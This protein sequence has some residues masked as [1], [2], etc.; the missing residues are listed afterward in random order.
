[1]RASRLLSIVL[2]LQNRGRLTGSELAAELEVSVRTIYRDIDSLSASGIPVIAD[3]GPAGGFRLLDGYRTRLTGLTPD[4][5]D[6]LFLAGAPGI[7]GELGLGAGMATAQLK[8]LAAL[9]DGLRER[10]ER[11]RGRFHLDAPGWYHDDDD[12]PFLPLVAE[13][14]WQ[15]RRVSWR[16]QRWGGEVDRTAEPLGLVLKGGV[17]YVVAAVDGTARTYRVSRILAADLLTVRFERPAMFDL[18]RYWAEWSEAFNERMYPRQATVRF[19]PAGQRLLSFFLDSY[20]TRMARASQGEPDEMGWVTA[21]LPME[22]FS[23]A[24]MELLRF[25][26]EI[27]VLDPPELRAQLADLAGAILARYAGSG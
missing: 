26:T 18:A 12:L 2:L 16:Y 9:P 6:T 20:R 23:H 13:A 10:A 14:V 3:R 25:G 4:E 1:M 19:S 7:A 27:D 17:W 21:S 8:L 15:Q 5:A 11:A 22:S 24:A